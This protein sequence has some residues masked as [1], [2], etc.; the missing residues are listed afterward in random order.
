MLFREN[1]KYKTDNQQVYWYICF[2]GI[3]VLR[4]SS[5]KNVNIYSNVPHLDYLCLKTNW[6]DT[7]TVIATHLWC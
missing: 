1:V 3:L 2:S 5:F 4:I 6:G 7:K